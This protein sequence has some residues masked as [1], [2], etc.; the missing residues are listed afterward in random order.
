M[1]EIKLQN[2]LYNDLINKMRTP[3]PWGAP[4]GKFYLL[5]GTITPFIPTATTFE[6]TTDRL[7]EQILI[8]LTRE[9]SPDIGVPDAK[10]PRILTIVPVAELTVISLQLSQGAN[11][12]MITTVNEPQEVSYLI[13]RAVTLVTLWQAFTTVFYGDIRRIID[14]QKRAISSPFATRLIE[15]F[16]SFQDLLPDLQS[17]QALSLKFLTR[18]MIHS[19]GTNDGVLDMLKALGLT[20]PVYQNMD[21]FTFDFD[22]ELDGWNN[23]ASQYG[24]QEAHVWLPNLGVAT[25]VA[26]IR[27][28][29]AHSDIYLL[30]RITENQVAVTIQGELQK[31]L[32]DFDRY[33]ADFLTSLSQSECFK[34]ITINILMYS[35]HILKFCAASY[36]FDLIITDPIDS[37]RPGFD[38]GIP[39]DSGYPFDSDPVDP[40]TDGWVGVSLTGRFEQNALE[41]HALDTFVV[42]STS[43]PGAYCSYAGFYT[44]QL[45]NHRWDIEMPVDIIVTGDIT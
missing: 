31:H 8:E 27:Y 32:F 11:K 9:E 3:D 30:E 13:V 26:F 4:K 45:T 1:L 19:V 38:S 22:P 16:I 18:G 24:G 44:Q 42:P 41:T 20:T 37:R 34:S 2:S 36:T 40:F 43:Y 17:L 23:V 7:N 25:W 14:E 33:G 39:F 10:Q 5:Q 35:L 15:P 12:I 29:E 28:I 6:V 21:K